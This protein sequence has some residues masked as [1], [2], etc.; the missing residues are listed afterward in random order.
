MDVQALAELMKSQGARLTTISAIM[1]DHGE[2]E[3][4]YHF[5]SGGQAVNVKTTTRANAIPS[6]ANIYT[7]ASWIERENHDLFGVEFTGHP[8]LKR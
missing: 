6:I 7:A 2:T 5:A 1:M 4:I 3:L 8:N